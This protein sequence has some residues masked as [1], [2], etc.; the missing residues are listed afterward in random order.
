[1]YRGLLFCGNRV[2]DGGKRNKNTVMGMGMGVCVDVD[3][4]MIG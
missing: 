4:D 2:R 3:M 1:L